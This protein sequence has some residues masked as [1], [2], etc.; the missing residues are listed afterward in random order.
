MDD[1]ERERYIRLIAD[2]DEECADIA[3]SIRRTQQE[4]W[5][6]LAGPELGKMM[7]SASETALYLTNPNPQLRETALYVL[8]DHWG[9]NMSLATTL[10]RM[11]CEDDDEIVRS[12]ALLYL[13]CLYKGSN[14]ASI[15]R[16]L[17][18]CVKDKSLPLGMRTNAYQGLFFLRG[19]S[20]AHWPRSWSPKWRFPAEVDWAFVNSFI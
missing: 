14:D 2:S 10:K 4:S 17:A 15:G 9:L 8:K 19:L 1:R 5:T 3:A 20:S 11:A 6:K 13:G 18:A 12:I 7:R 16:L